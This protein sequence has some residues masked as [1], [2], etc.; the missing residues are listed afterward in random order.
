MRVLL[1]IFLFLSAFQSAIAQNFNVNNER[2]FEYLYL[3]HLDT[4]VDFHAAIKPYNKKE[5]DRIIPYDTTISQ[6]QLSTSKGFVNQLFNQHLIEKQGNFYFNINPIINAISTLEKAENYSENLLETSAGA[7]LQAALGEKWSSEFAFLYDYST[8]PSHIDAMIQSKNISPG[9]GYTK[10][11]A[12][13]F[14]QGNLTFT[15]NDVFTIQAGYG[16]HFIGDGYRSLLLSD[17]ANSY[18]YLKATANIWKIKYMALYS[19]HQD[20]RFTDGIYNNYMQKFATTHYLSMNVT[21]WLNLGFF[22]SIVFQSQEKEFYRGYDLSY[23]NPIIFLRSTEYALG[24]SDNALMGGS[25]KMRILKKYIFYG[26]LLFDEFLLEELKAGNGWWANKYGVQAGLKFIEPL[27]IK[28]LRLQLEYNEV[29][30]F[31]YSYFYRST[32][33]STLQNY[34]HFNAPLAHPIGANF[35]EIT[36]SAFYAKKRWIFELHS[37]LAKVGLD[38]NGYSLGQDVYQPYNN[39]EDDYGY[40]TLNGLKTNIINNTVKISYVLNPKSNMILQAGVTNRTFTNNYAN[41]S[42][43]MFFIGL[44]TAITNRYSDF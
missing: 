11:D 18:P 7:Q 8:Y 14:S 9:Y 35:K 21:K 12:A 22:E 15:P 41:L 1:Y 31:T 13:I 30:P 38:T 5:V 24:S 36:A 33:V 2:T 10:N 23:L 20:I 43:N 17:F 19:N 4:A 27:N 39:R 34:A 3:N 40:Y 6:L 42:S 25:I 37:T 16:K 44:K 26:Q 28:R 29:R 32:N